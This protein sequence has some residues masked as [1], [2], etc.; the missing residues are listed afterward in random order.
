MRIAVLALVCCS[1]AYAQDMGVL[2]NLSESKFGPLPGLPSCVMGAVQSGD[3]STGGSVIAL[4]GTA[5]CT[6]PWHW[7]TPTERVIVVSGSMKF[8]MK[9]SGKSLTLGAG[10]YAEMPTKHVHQAKCVSAC[11]AFVTSDKAFDIHYV[12]ASGNEIP[13][14]TAL[15]KKPR[16][17]AAAATHHK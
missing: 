7:H 8:E 1:A 15:A 13:P 12:D 14:E 4:K 17:L 9:D 11:T 16:P 3:P 6:I 10:G 5:G 2:R